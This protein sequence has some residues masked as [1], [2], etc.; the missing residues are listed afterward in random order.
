MQRSSRLRTVWDSIRTSFWFVPSIMMVSAIGLAGLGFWLDFRFAGRDAQS[1]P[2]WVYVSSPDD[3]RNVL[4][5][6]LSS[7]ITMTSLVFSITM[8]VLSLAANQFGPRLIRNFMASPQTQTVL[9]IFVMTI[10]Y[11]LLVLAAIGWRGSEGLFSF[12][13]IT[14]AIALMAV[15][16][17]LLVLF[18]HTLA[19]GNA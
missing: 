17:A 11:C 14:I 18:L 16:I 3:A 12:S 15:S 4:S 6:L 5:T 19:R 8:V 13:T 1:V 9:G 7:M 10:L 2:W